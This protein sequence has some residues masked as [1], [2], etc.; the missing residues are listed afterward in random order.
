MGSKLGAR[1]ERYLQQ[2][3]LTRWS[4]LAETEESLDLARLRALHGPARALKQQVDRVL[5]I[6]EGRLA[7]GGSAADTGAIPRPARA[8]WAWRPEA[9]RA[10]LTVPGRA[11]VETRTEI[12]PGL[13]LHHDCAASEVTLRQIRNRSAADPA[14]F[15]LTFDVFGFDGSFLSLAVE[16][17]AAAVEGLRNRHLMRLDAVIETERPLEI[18]ARLNLKHGPN[19]EQTVR[20]LPRGGGEVMAEF[21]LAYMKLNGTRVEQI[22]VDLIFEGPEMNRITLGDLAFCRRPRAEL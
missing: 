5:R 20:E 19:V 13:T 8:D 16:L 1:V 9:W 2:R 4:R 22:W 15:G 12:G 7:T 18:F 17:P 21:D 10:P 11:G 6:A 3:V 14:P